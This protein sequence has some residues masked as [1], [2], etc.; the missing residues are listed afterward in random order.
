MQAPP[1]PRVVGVMLSLFTLPW[2]LALGKL[3]LTQSEALVALLQ[4]GNRA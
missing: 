3:A 2:S 1:P 4:Q